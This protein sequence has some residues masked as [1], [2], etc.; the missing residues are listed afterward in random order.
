MYCRTAAENISDAQIQ[1]QIDVLNEDFNATN[2]DFIPVP[3]LF[4]ALLLTL[5]S[6]LF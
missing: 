3:A 6:L 5:E 2:S 1:S 4:L